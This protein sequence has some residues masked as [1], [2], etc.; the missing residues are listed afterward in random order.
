[1]TSSYGWDDAPLRD[2]KLDRA[3]R[4]PGTLISAAAGT[5]EE[6]I[7]APGLILT[8]EQLIDLKR[9]ESHGLALPTALKD[10]IWYLGY[11]KGAGPNLEARDF[12]ASFNRIHLHA[13]QWNPLRTDLMNVG[14]ELWVFADQMQVY[15]NAARQLYAEI[16]AKPAEALVAEDQADFLHYVQQVAALVLQRRSATEALK[17]RLDAFARE[18]STT[19]MP[20]VQLKIRSIDTS[21]LPADIQSLNSVINK[22]AIDIEEKQREYQTLVRK[23]VSASFLLIGMGIYYGVE[24]D[25]VRKQ[26]N[27]LRQ[28]QQRS[29][30]LLE[31]KNRIHASLQRVRHDLH[32]L[33]LVIFDADIATQN[34]VIVW[35]DLHLY[36]THSVE[37][38]GKIDS[39]LTLRR[40]MNAFNLVAE[41]WGQI[42]RDADTLLKVFKEA[43]R[44]FRRDY[45]HQ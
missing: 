11:E 35:N 23:S 10:V 22:R 40:L 21:R 12:Q 37:E 26:L 1:M 25:K 3:Q 42:K 7:R 9:Y 27:T 4:L 28:E 13:A 36:L 2:E 31:Q 38:A 43:D 29:I 17:R 16:R 32:D 20:D 39:A 30:R 15:G 8:K 6:A 24:A 33:S 45:G 44:D 19:L 14:S 34:L 41:P 5:A 18:L